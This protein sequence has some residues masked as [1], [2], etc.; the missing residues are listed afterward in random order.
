MR[1]GILTFHRAHNYGAV[2]Q[3]YALQQYLIQEGH[4]VYVIDYNNKQLWSY[5]NWRNR[6]LEKQIKKNKIK[7][8]IRLYRYIKRRKMQILRYYKFVHFQKHKLRLSNK[9][10]I[11]NFPYDLIL[12][13]SDQVWST[14]I[15]HGLDPYY[16]GTFEKPSST[17]VATYAASLRGVWKEIHHTSIHDALR[18]LDGISVRESAVG[19]YVTGLFPDLSVFHV[20]DPVLLLSQIQ[21]KNLAKSP[22]KNTP[23]AFFYQAETS[24]SVYNTALEIALQHGLPLYV[25]SA[26]QWAV[27][28]RDCHAASP[29][30]FLGWI[31]NANLVVTSSFHALA[32][33]ILFQKEFFAVN[34]PTEQDER[35]R[36]ICSIF[37]VEDRLIDNPSQ[38]KKFAPFSINDG[39]ELLKKETNTYFSFLAKKIYNHQ[40]STT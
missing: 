38:C 28:S 23:Y 19:N 4:D 18:K 20:P 37:G 9:E 40:E 10:S 3:C 15:T 2:L 16:W 35:M 34:L 5:Y 24:E 11:L 26:D 25:L 14:S 39:I 13:G 1:I 30:D 29:F 7:F 17:K 21:W 32:F 12:I 8:P 33:C 31:L 36:S 22:S 6:E 27:N